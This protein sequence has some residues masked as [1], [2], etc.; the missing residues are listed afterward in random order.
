MWLPS[1]VVF[2]PSGPSRVLA[3]AS[4]SIDWASALRTLR[5]ERIGLV[6]LSVMWLKF[7]ADERWILTPLMSWARLSRFTAEPMPMKSSSPLDRASAW[8]S[9]SI[10]R[11][12]IVS[13]MARFPHHLSLRVSVIVWAIVS[14]DAIL[15]GPAAVSALAFQPSLK[16]FGALLVDAGYRGGSRLCQSTKVDAQVPTDS[17]SPRPTPTP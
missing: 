11:K 1:G 4:R 14:T 12:M 7:G 8:A 6:P 2:T 5:S 17:R 15:N 10:L 16:V 9:R 3:T 13:S